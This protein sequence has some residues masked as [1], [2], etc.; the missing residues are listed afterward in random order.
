V[1]ATGP[2]DARVHNHPRT[3]SRWSE[4]GGAAPRANDSGSG[5]I[6]RD[7]PSN[8]TDSG[9]DWRP[10]FTRTMGSVNASST[11]GGLAGLGHKLDVRLS[12]GAGTGGIS[13]IINAG[14]AYANHKW[15]F[16][17]SGGHL[18]GLGP[19]FGLG[20]EALANW[21]VLSQAPPWFGFLDARG[22]A[23]LDLPPGTLP[24]GIDT[25]DIFI[26]Q[27]PAGGLV[28][29]TAVLEFDT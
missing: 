25:D 11:W 29:R 4:F 17:V 3:P 26:L 16:F 2:G 13:I 19:F 20:P 18:N 7:S 21:M 14:L 9:A 1:R 22:S 23:R 10:I 6:G 5:C 27:D 8:D 24:P 15:S 12:D 28:L